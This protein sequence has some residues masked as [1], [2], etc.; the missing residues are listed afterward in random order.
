[1]NSFGF[2]YQ[3]VDSFQLQD[4]TYEAKITKV[5]KN[6]TS[7]GKKYVTVFFCIGGNDK[8]TPNRWMSFDRPTEGFGMFTVEQA[9]HM[10]DST[11]TKFFDSF[12][13]PRGN[14]DTNAWVGHSGEV[15]VRQ[16]KKDNRYKEIVPYA[17]QKTS[18]Q[19]TPEVK[20]TP[21]ETP[22]SEFPEDIVF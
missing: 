22:A 13:I 18:G 6:V 21:V 11:M 10:W 5:E 16:Q 4:G 20:E 2:G 17:M 1:M 12:K 19:K 7:Q 14:F 15:T 9:Q 8:S 3:P